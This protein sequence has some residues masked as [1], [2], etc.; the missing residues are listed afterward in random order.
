MY[1]SKNLLPFKYRKVFS[2]SL[3]YPNLLSRYNFFKIINEKSPLQFR[4]T[5]SYASGG[6]RDCENCNLYTKKSRS[7]K[8]LYYLGAKCL[9]TL[10][11][12]LRH[13]ESA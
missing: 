9:N 1:K 5:F 3:M 13:A 8:Q 11:Q 10:P 7:N 12:S 6:S 2:N 4:D